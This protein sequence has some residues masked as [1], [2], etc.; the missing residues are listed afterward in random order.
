MSVEP[1]ALS[2]REELEA[3]LRRMERR[4]EATNEKLARLTTERCSLLSHT[5]LARC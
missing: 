2:V 1:E 3:R 5:R 4:L